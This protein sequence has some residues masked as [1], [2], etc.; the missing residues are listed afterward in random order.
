M[1]VECF[2]LLQLFGVSESSNNTK[3]LEKNRSSVPQLRERK[4]FQLLDLK[5]IRSYSVRLCDLWLQRE[6]VKKNVTTKIPVKF[7]TLSTLYFSHVSRRR[8]LKS[9]NFY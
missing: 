7:S 6:L 5:I 1:L 2:Q 4:H 9:L 3:Y 8:H